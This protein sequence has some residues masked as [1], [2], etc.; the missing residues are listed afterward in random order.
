ME[1][2]RYFV[3]DSFYRDARALRRQLDRALS[4]ER[5]P[6]D[7]ARFAWE[8]WHVPWQFSQLRAP[9]RAIF[10][11]LLAA[12]EARVLARLGRELGVVAFGGPPW[13]SILRDRDFQALHRDSPNGHLAFSFGL[14]REAKFRGGETLIANDELLDYFR[15][16]AHRDRAAADPM[17][18]VVPSRFNRIVVF[19]ARLPHAVREV[20][21]PREP[22]HGRITIQGW[23]RAGTFIP[24]ADASTMRALARAIGTIR[25][26]DVEGLVVATPKAI[27]MHTLAVTGERGNKAV[28]AALRAIAAAIRR[29]RLRHD[30]RTAV[31]FEAG[32]ARLLD[33]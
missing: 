9:A 31:V 12:W 15:K 7:A 8:A 16:G 3:T 10:G 11:D 28:P 25:A 29:L 1:R 17:F 33:S 5:D 22:R 23:L 32:R 13:I 20:E 30:A 24:D 21:G 19:D 6:F 26:A 14:G 27:V 2:F 18:D 4:D